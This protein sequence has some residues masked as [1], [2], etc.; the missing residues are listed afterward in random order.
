MGRRRKAGA[1]T[2]A[3]ATALPEAA[4]A[5]LREAASARGTTV[6]QLI[7][8]AVMGLVLRLLRES[9]RAVALQEKANAAQ[10]E[11][12]GRDA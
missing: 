4:V 11:K 2:G 1:Y 5:V 9:T 6:G 7:R 10:E 3:V 8:P 12:E